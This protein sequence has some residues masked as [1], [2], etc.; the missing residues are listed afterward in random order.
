MI[1]PEYTRTKEDNRLLLEALTLEYK[2]NARRT[3]TR[4]LKQAYNLIALL[5]GLLVVL[6]ITALL[7]N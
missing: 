2:Y 5:L 7:Y 3:R 6:S 1:K 4:R